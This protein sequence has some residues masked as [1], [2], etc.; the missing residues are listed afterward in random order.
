MSSITLMMS[1][2]FCDWVLISCMVA[3][4][5]RIT[6]PPS[7]ATLLAS[8]ASAVARWALS[9]LCCTVMVSC[10]IDAAVSCRLDACTSVRRAR[11]S[12]P[13]AITTASWATVS[14]LARTSVITRTS[15]WFISRR[16]PSSSAVSS[17]PRTSIC[18]VRSPPATVRASTTAWRSGREMERVMT[19]AIAAPASSAM[20]VAASI[21]QWM[22]SLM[23]RAPANS[24]A[25]TLICRATRRSMA[26]CTLSALGRIW[27]MYSSE[28]SSYLPA[29]S[30]ADAGIRPLSR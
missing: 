11:S 18:A 3:I 9:V 13:P 2:I 12:V 7:L 29:T 8:C 1:V 17:L 24:A 10:S 26:S 16:A 30:A 19:Q 15:W 14:V 6:L 27:V 5:S 25:A 20:A 22:V 28:P 4:T 23:A 21:H